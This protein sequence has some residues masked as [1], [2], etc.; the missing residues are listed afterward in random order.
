MRQKI[1][2]FSIGF[3]LY[4]LMF[5]TL[6]FIIEDNITGYKAV[7]AGFIFGTFMGLYEVFIYPK[8]R[9]YFTKKKQ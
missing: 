1:I 9:N 2:T 5:G 6:M 7:K 8:M 3:I 4:G